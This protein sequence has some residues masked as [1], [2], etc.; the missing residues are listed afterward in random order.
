MEPTLLGHLSFLLTLSAVAAGE[1]RALAPLPDREGFAGAF[2][3]VSH[4]ALLFA[5]G[6]NFPG[7]KPWEGGQKVWYDQVYVLDAPGGSW[8][9]AGTLPRPLGY[10][11]SV[12]FGQGVVCVGG[13]DAKANTAEAF[14][15]EWRE[16]AL[17][18]TRL[19]SLPMPL[20]NA[21]GALVG[22]RLYLAGG[23][24]RPD[25]RETL[26]RVWTID[27]AAAAPG[28]TEVDPWPGPARML[29]AAAGSDGAFWIA[30][31]VD[32]VTTGDGPPVR[33]YL[34]DAYRYDP[35]RGWTK[36]AD[37]PDPV[38]APPSP[39][40]AD[41]GGFLILGGDDG[42]QVGAAPTAHRGFRQQILR[43]DLASKTWQTAGTLPAPRVTTPCVPWGTSWVVPSGEIRPGVRSPEV[44][45]F[46]PGNEE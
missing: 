34:K 25:S 43:Y 22:S 21:S 28:W 46:R 4:G 24:E 20:A 17:V 1:W 37:L 19:P 45:S 26:R 13:G 10:G 39:A 8:K 9:A 27:L 7:R 44:W 2:A 18:T 16:G 6:A 31:G 12:T 3:G 15:L 14:R 33:K 38:T 42:A 23:Q 40:P 29:A 36:V 5:G 41:A 30:G 11:V 35:G 32:L